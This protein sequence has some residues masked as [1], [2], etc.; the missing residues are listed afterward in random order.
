VLLVRALR[1]TTYILPCGMRTCAWNR[2]A[3]ACH[4][5]EPAAPARALAALSSSMSML[6]VLPLLLHAMQLPDAMHAGACA[7]RS[8][9][10]LA[11]CLYHGPS[12]RLGRRPR[13]SRRGVPFPE[14]LH[15][16]LQLPLWHR[17]QLRQRLHR[18]LAARHGPSGIPAG[19]RNAVCRLH[20]SGVQQQQQQQQQQQ[21]WW[22]FELPR[23][24]PTRRR[25]DGWIVRGHAAVRVLVFRA[26]CVGPRGAPVL[27]W[28]VLAYLL[29]FFCVRAC[30]GGARA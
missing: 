28:R 18:D 2:S 14:P 6:C 15:G 8:K 19:R 20:P 21:H 16:R 5:A 27:C 4:A 24:L 17:R 30:V 1:E 10:K 13:P 25:G 12:A 7:Y 11:R 29:A 22:S 23:D 3:L 26:G 9:R